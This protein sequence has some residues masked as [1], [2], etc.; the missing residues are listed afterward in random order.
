MIHSYTL[1]D[2]YT[3]KGNEVAFLAAKKIIELPGEVFN[4]FYIY[5]AEG[6]GK[7][8]LLKAID[9]ELSKKRATLF[10]SVKELEKQL[11]ESTLFDSP[12]I[13]DD[14]HTINEAYKARL[15][16]MIERAVEENVQ[17]CLSANDA[18]QNIGGFSPTLCAL[19][20]SGLICN[21]QPAMRED[22]A[23]LIK[24]KA[25]EAGIILPDDLAETLAQVGTGSIKT[26][27]N[28]I[29]RLVTFTSLGD[30]PRDE[31]TLRTILADF[32]PKRKVC[33]VPLVLGTLKSEDIWRL[34]STERSALRREYET[35]MSA[36][37]AKG[38]D[39]SLLKDAMQHG[40]AELGKAY[41]DF[42]EKVYKLIA[43][44][45]IF[46]DR[47]AGDDRIE[48]MHIE[49]LIF[50][51]GKVK[52]IEMLLTPSE[53]DQKDVKINRTFS[54]YFL[55]ACNREAW[56][57]YHDE[58]LENLGEHNPCFVFGVRGTG[59]T[60]FLEAISDDL[61]SR[62]KRVAF[63]DMAGE[64]VTV[65]I[66]DMESNDVLVLDDFHSVLQ[67][68]S[69]LNSIMTVIEICLQSN[70]QVFIGS[71]PIQ[72]VLP[73]RVE[74][75]MDRGVSIE[76]GKPSA[77]VALEYIEKHAPCKAAE[78]RGREM[79]VFDSFYDIDYYVQSSDQ[80]ESP[81]IPLGLPGESASGEGEVSIE[82]TVNGPVKILSAD[83][84]LAHDPVDSADEG[85]YMMPDGPE[86]LVE[87]KF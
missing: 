43:L 9:S 65:S 68:A 64:D 34:A 19:I 85:R 23:A 25:E 48:T 78:L 53:E 82:E 47:S 33:A 61:I 80:E 49:S 7:T 37:Q 52:E 71:T 77:D 59:K 50:D 87:E 32:Y 54:E 69:R 15:L 26:I 41:D 2:F 44:Q 57:T 3:H 36:W 72:E 30:I 40:G 35:K 75:I 24:K 13:V 51:P 31:E 76:L 84:L 86:E 74:S 12:L 67:E 38:F 46:Y 66:S 16:E 73:E 11:D 17:V 70:K 58:V 60:H 10:L 83:L 27:V 55:G 79:P 56:S 14:I 5:G 18:P 8:H 6:L 29:N 22:Q 81:V 42:L 1:E 63:F 21:L 28:M 39:I 4:P 62:M 20:E 45:R